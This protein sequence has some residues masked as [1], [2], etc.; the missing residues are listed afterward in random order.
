MHFRFLRVGVSVGLCSLITLFLIAPLISLLA[1]P[2]SPEITLSTDQN[3]DLQVVAG[4]TVRWHNTSTSPH[5]LRAIDNSWATPLIQPGETVT[6]T[7]T[8]P[9]QSLFVC[10]IDPTIRG[11]VTVQSGNT[12]FVP[13]V[14][15]RTVERWSQPGTWGA[16]LPQAGAAVTI[17]AGKVVLLDTSPPPLQSLLI[18]GELIFDRRDL[19][20]TVGWIM[21]HGNGR[22][23]IGSPSEPFTHRATITL[24]ASDPN[25]DVMGM[26]TRGILLMGGTFEAYG[27]IPN[28]VWTT[29]NDHAAAGATNL[30]LRDTVDWQ[31]G[32]QIVIAPTDYYGVAETERLTVQ[33]VSGSH[34]T[35]AMPLTRARWGRLQYVSPTSLTETPTT[36]VTPLVLDERAEVGL[37]SR[38]I[39]IQGADD[40]LWRDQRFGAHIMV[41]DHAV[42]RLDGVELRR[43]GQGGRLGRYPIH[44]HMI[45]YTEDGR[46]I[47]DSPAQLVANSSIWNSANRC[48]TIHSTNGT[49]IRNNVCYDI[50]GHA[51]FLEDAVERR[52]VIEG[53]LVLRVRQPP[54]PLLPSDRSSFRRGPSGFWLTNPDNV[55]RGNVAADTAGNGFW[56][57]FPERSLGPSKRVPMRPNVI[58]LGIFS[59]NVAHSNSKPG[60]NI[61][62]APVDDEGNTAERKYTPTNDGEPYR[63]SNGVR[64]TLSDITT[65]KNNDNGLWNRVSLPDYVRFVAAD[66]AGMFF[67][68]AGDNGKIYD[69]LIV[70]ESL[71][72][73]NVPVSLF[74]NQ[75]NAAIASYHSTFD[76]FDN[77][78]VNFPLHPRPDRASGAFATNDYYT[79]PVDR[80]LVR[81]P[82]NRLINAHPG[83]RVISPNI[84]T[85]TGNATL[86]GALWDPH[87]YWGP[88]GNYWVYDIP[89]LTAGQ[90][91]GAVE[92]VGQNGRSCRG[93]YYGVAGFRIDNSDLYK[94][95]MP[96]TITRLDAD[97]QPIGQWVVEEGFSGMRNTFAIMQWMRHFATVSGGRYLVE[98]R[99]GSTSLPPPTHELRLLLSNM[100]TTSDQI[101][102][103]VP[104][105]SGSGVVAYLTTRE[106]YQ[107]AEAG[108]PER[109][110]LMPVNSFAAM[111]ATDNSMWHDQAN[112]RV[113]INVRGGVPIFGDELADPLSDASLYRETN[114]R[115]YRP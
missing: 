52:N 58:P 81:N 57:A 87:G 26:G 108:A 96:L 40:T 7:F 13:L 102:L 94:S 73:H 2:V 76:I 18:E 64:F 107:N 95:L 43:V 91:C 20:L 92:P 61:D 5:R 48:I 33:A 42:L 16:S 100:H 89:F 79:R 71:N 38:R 110:D 114:V 39:V 80:G 105:S 49:T 10:D 103:G 34:V 28:R 41:M 82:N 46:F 109:R 8:M 77:V 97:N 72:N 22:L 111:L 29:L 68:G 19:D 6:Q 104:F 51:I 60:I 101:I 54:Q 65:Y 14:V 37:L 74:T 62:F 55:V 12:I 75:P 30:T 4:Q 83:R 78:I 50:A 53:N 11:V 47:G 31:S 23:R 44:F 32:D 35:L 56:L 86:A 36:A 112:Q 17:P 99:D 27:L 1:A 85:P 45:S 84:H 93:P 59:H 113:W 24:N 15:G 98:F 67:A 70:G 115:I 106:L 66:N 63:V 9:G 25:E 88:A 90:E 3:Y 69:S 21:L